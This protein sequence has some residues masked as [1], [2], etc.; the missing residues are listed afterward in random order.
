MS[1]LQRSCVYSVNG[2]LSQVRLNRPLVRERLK[3]S[4]SQDFVPAGLCAEP[5]MLNCTVLP[6]QLI[7]L[8]QLPPGDLKVMPLLSRIPVSLLYR[9]R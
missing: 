5:D 1:G 4:L 6:W 9:F 7:I 3:V 8:R 2:P